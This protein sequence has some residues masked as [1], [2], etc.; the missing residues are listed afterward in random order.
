MF[1]AVGKDCEAW[2]LAMDRLCV[3]LDTSGEKPA[4]FCVTTSHLE[5][6]VEAVIEFASNW[7]TD[8]HQKCEIEISEI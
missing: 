4:A 7:N 2:E 5:A 3:S 1:C 6:T 8:R